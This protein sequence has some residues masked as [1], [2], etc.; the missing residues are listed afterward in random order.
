MARNLILYFVAM[1]VLGFGTLPAQTRISNGVVAN[2]A[3]LLSGES[4]QIVGTLG[5]AT[6]ATTADDIEKI[7]SGFWNQTVDI[8]TTVKGP[9]GQALPSKFSLHQNYPNPF[10]PITTIQFDI[11]KQ[12]RVSIRVYNILGKEIATLVDEEK[13][14]GIYTIQFDGGSLPTGVYFY[15]LETPDGFAATRKLMLL[16]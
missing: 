14:P 6:I 16:K 13:A 3:A 11:P 10:N 5:Q 9:P 4:S 2:G 1:V 8:V 15:R 7:H 12:S